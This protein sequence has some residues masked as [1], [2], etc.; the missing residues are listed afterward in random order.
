MVWS[1]NILFFFLFFSGIAHAQNIYWLWLSPKNA[2]RL[3]TFQ[4]HLHFSEKAVTRRTIQNIPWDIKDLPV[5]SITLQQVS[6]L[7]GI[8]IRGVSRWLNAISVECDDTTGLIKQWNGSV[9]SISRAARYY[10][11]RDSLQINR[12]HSGPYWSSVYGLSLKGMELLNIPVMHRKGYYGSSVD[13]AVIDAGFY[14]MNTAQ[15]FT[16]LF[17]DGRILG[18]KDFAQPG[19]DVYQADPH[20]TAV[21]SVMAALTQGELYGVAPNASYWLLRSE[22]ATA[23]YITEED[24]W[25][26]AAEFADS[27]G[28]QIINSS[29]GYTTFDNPAEDHN[30]YDL[31]GNTTTIARAADIAA[32]RGILVVNSAGNY[33]SGPW[34]YIGSPADADSVL[35]VGATDING[36]RATFSSVGPTADGRIKPDVMALGYQAALYSPYAQAAGFGNGTSFSAPAISGMAALF[37]NAFPGVSSFTLYNLFKSCSSRFNMP[38][39]AMGF[40]IPDAYCMYCALAQNCNTDGASDFSVIHLNDYLLVSF[41][42]P[43]NETVSFKITDTGGRLMD[44]QQIDLQ[45]GYNTWSIALQTKNMAAGIYILNVSS[46]KF[47]VAHKFAIQ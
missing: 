11:S 40:G 17:H 20:G 7:E 26:F 21:M 29:L 23:E 10:R 43:Q 15:P 4:P 35:A 25:V 30:Y 38:D 16:H 12:S 33:G 22:D 2:E 36:E 46:K 1:R 47:N 14:N 24:N 31:D 42:L 9:K 8:R 6:L 45:S 44:E 28:A 5:D 27:V 3:T 18:T 39:T 13:I 41:E 37:Y 34:K 32:S 19:G